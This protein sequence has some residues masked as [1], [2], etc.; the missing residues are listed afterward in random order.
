MIELFDPLWAAASPAPLFAYVGPG[1]GLSMA[2]ALLGLLVTL[3][4]AVG[5]VAFWPIRVLLR[6]WRE[7]RGARQAVNLSQSE[8]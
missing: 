7:R 5:A 8:P 4:V 2:S 1:P 6:R 3:F